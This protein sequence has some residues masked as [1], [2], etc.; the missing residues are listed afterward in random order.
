MPAASSRRRAFAVLFAVSMT[1]AAG[2]TAL[3]SV[4]P[5]IGRE[6]GVADTLIVAVFSLSAFFWTVTSSFWARESDRRGRKRLILIGLSGFSISMLAVAVAVSAG[7]FRLVAP[8]VAFGGMLA[9]RSIFG[10]VGSAAT[11]AAQAY[12][13]DRTAPDE[14]T[15]ALA[16]LASAIGLGTVLGPALAPFFVL[17]HVGLAGPMFVFAVIGAAVMVVVAR[18]LP[19]GDAEPQLNGGRPTR[20]ESPHRGLWRDRRV[21]PFVVYGFLQ[22][23]V[24]AINVQT[25][26][27]LV[28]D[29]LKLAPAAAQSFIG[30]AMLAGAGATLLAQWG[31]IRMLRLSP[32][33]LL[34]WGAVLA[35]GGNLII[36]F[37]G[38]YYGLVVGYA[39]VSLGYGFCRPGYTAGAS[40]AVG[41]DEQ[42]A[43]A[44]VMAA[45][46]GACYLVA[47][48]AGVALYERF[49]PTPFLLNLAV[50]IGLL[51]MAFRSPALRRAG[52]PAPE[53]AA[54][55]ATPPP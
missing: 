4:L 18:L 54:E 44:G 14:R 15:P 29:R 53:E 32:R 3:Q 37:A 25:L 2:N 43:V 39:L 13:A 23:S 10:L 1:T 8:L 6:V 9:G 49:G 48:M 12:V 34:R 47:P 41:R 40:L 31:L 30:I 26:G 33:D 28:I 24:Q 16:A 52:T 7:V 35:A 11:P 36:A 45:I 19:S 38:S 42:G 27:F 21:A 51:A 46:S 17:P 22:G 55:Q 5:A 50:L 20:A